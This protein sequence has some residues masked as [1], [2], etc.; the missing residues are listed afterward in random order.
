MKPASS[1]HSTSSY[2][3]NHRFPPPNF[4]QQTIV[5]CCP[6]FGVPGA[7]TAAVVAEQ[8]NLS[9]QHLKKESCSTTLQGLLF[10]RRSRGPQSAQPFAYEFQRSRFFECVHTFLLLPRCLLLSRFWAGV[11]SVARG[12]H[13]C[14]GAG[15]WRWMPGRVYHSS[16]ISSLNPWIHLL[17]NLIKTH[18][19][20]STINAYAPY[21]TQ[22]DFFK[23][24]LS[25]P[26]SSPG[27]RVPTIK[28][29]GRSRA[30]EKDERR[31]ALSPLLFAR[32]SLI[33]HQT[34]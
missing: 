28:R 10:S 12:G 34:G 31:P 14:R 27:D 29:A 11:I 25:I 33:G 21:C 9:P 26:V 7:A 23:D 32:D 8:L 20:T 17:K 15:D 30:G 1:R 5:A 24:F 3:S 19:C 22:F 16:K 4:P 18:A 6:P 2:L 13:V